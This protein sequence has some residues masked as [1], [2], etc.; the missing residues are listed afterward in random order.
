MSD[1]I[2]STK[3]NICIIGLMG[4]GK[5]IIGKEFSK[6]HDMGFY[7]SDLEIE[8]KIGK[9]VYGAKLTPF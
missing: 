8:R 5:S 9:K 2:N 1:F 3:M 7:D 4:S 6:I